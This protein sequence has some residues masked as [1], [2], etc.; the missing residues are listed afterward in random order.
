M[1]IAKLLTIGI[2]V[3]VATVV[4]IAP[5][6]NIVNNY[7]SNKASMK[8]IPLLYALPLFI[9]TKYVQL[10]PLLIPYFTAL[11]YPIVLYEELTLIAYAKLSLLELLGHLVY[12]VCII[13]LAY[14][15]LTL[16]YRHLTGEL[17]RERLK[18]EVVEAFKGALFYSLIG[19]VISSL[20]ILLSL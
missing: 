3:L 20:L 16:T 6:M 12:L 18:H 15:G 7:N 2:L 19:V 5:N 9:V 13:V 10:L 8:N 17:G 11:Y 4:F 1:E 14:V